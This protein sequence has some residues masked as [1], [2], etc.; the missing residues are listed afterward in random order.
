MLRTSSFFLSSCPVSLPYL[1]LQ[2]SPGQRTILLILGVSLPPVNIRQPRDLSGVQISCFLLSCLLP[3]APAKN[4]TP[5]TKPFMSQGSATGLILVLW[6]GHILSFLGLCHISPMLQ[7]LL[8]VSRLIPRTEPQPFTP[9]LQVNVFT[10]SGRCIQ[11]PALHITKTSFWT[12]LQ[13][14]H[15]G[16]V[17]EHYQAVPPPTLQP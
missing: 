4:A 15:P 7:H 11:L 12:F 14:G 13:P 9:A 3:W 2:L 1:P 6:T 5:S 17:L 16:R 10:A 8:V